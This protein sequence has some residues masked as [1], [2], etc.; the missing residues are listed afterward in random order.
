MRKYENVSLRFLADQLNF[1]HDGDWQTFQ[2]DAGEDEKK[3]LQD[4][5]KKHKQH[6]NHHHEHKPHYHG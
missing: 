1:L 3:R 2:D 5:E 6:E 4:L